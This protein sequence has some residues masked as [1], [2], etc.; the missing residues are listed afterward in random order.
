MR[1]LLQGV[2]SGTSPGGG[3]PKREAVLFSEEGWA[4]AA[5]T[6][7]YR[8][9]TAA[10][11]G[12]D[13][14]D[15]ELQ[16]EYPEAA[17]A[18][19][20]VEGEGETDYSHYYE[21]A[22]EA[23]KEE[24]AE[25]VDEEAYDPAYHIDGE[26]AYEGYPEG[27]QAEIAEDE[28]AADGLYAEEEVEADPDWYVTAGEA[29]GEEEEEE[30]V[31]EE[32]A[33][34]E[35]VGEV[36]AEADD[37]TANL[38]LV[39]Y[40]L[41]QIAKRVRVRHVE[42]KGRCLYTRSA[43]APGEVI[44]VEKPV[45][46]AVPSLN[47]ELWDLLTTL[48]EE[49]A[50]DLPPIW[51]LAALSS[52][53]SLGEEGFKICMDKWVPETDREPSED[54]LRVCSYIEG[55]IDP[56]MYERMLL[57][58]RYNSFG[59][60]S[61]AQGLVLYN[62]ISMMAHSCKATACWHYGEDDAFVLRARVALQEGD[63]ITIS[64]IGD[65]ELFKSTNVRREK[66]QGWLFTCQCVRC[67]TCGTGSMFFKT[68]D[69]V[70][71]SSPCTLC[72]TVPSE[73]TI[74]EYVTFETA[75]AERLAE[76]SKNDMPD[77]ETVYEQATRVFT[78]HWILFQ[79]DTILFEGY[80]AAGDYEAAYV[81]QTHRLN[82]VTEVLPLASYSLAWLYEEMGDVLWSRI[83]AKGKPYADS[84]LRMAGRHFEDAYN[85][86]YILCGPDHEYTSAAA[87][88]RNKVDELTTAI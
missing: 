50:F 79:L 67:A 5:S 15:E 81:H 10:A 42:G 35:Q 45:L 71:T 37:Q 8:H 33:E 36:E 31:E 48:N 68:D 27:E 85:L 32:A 12:E 84:R 51:H 7:G 63:E 54:V 52:L 70:T 49:A 43:L 61:E 65:D 69:D 88:K 9:P 13:E 17:Y 74:N 28:E 25:A 3:R 57:V 6:P 23:E 64:Y 56:H 11:A 19:A 21:D 73:D 18:E 75:Y 34:E 62:R 24:E 55:E 66:V 46:V 2:T 77:A 38:P 22:A 83:Q 14:T 86:L 80:R 20:E 82:Y 1:R 53:T 39:P 72:G 41:G 26:T 30:Q 16:H 40:T 76:T 87:S 44:F 78:R 4:R 59:H 47:P 60:H 29:E 58:W